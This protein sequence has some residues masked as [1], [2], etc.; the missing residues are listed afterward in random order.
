M[1]KFNE[2][3]K[4]YAMTM[5][6][7][8]IVVII[9]A[10]VAAIFI[11]MPKKNVSKLDRAKYYIAYD[12]L[13]KLQNEQLA[14]AGEVKIGLDSFASAVNEYLNTMGNMAA[15]ANQQ[16]TL[17]NGMILTVVNA[18]VIDNRDGEAQKDT[19]GDGVI[20]E[21]DQRTQYPYLEVTVDIDGDTNGLPAV[22]LS[23]LH[24]FWLYKDG[25]VEPCFFIDAGGNFVNGICNKNPNTDPNC[26]AV[27]CGGGNDWINFKVYTIDG[28]GNIQFLNDRIS[29]DVTETYTNVPYQKA[30]NRYLECMYE[31]YTPVDAADHKGSLDCY[32][33][34]NPPLK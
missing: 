18:G 31:G 13:N 2:K 4:K 28:N 19:N 17:T 29:G 12:L 30:R 20:D 34:A 23:D 16:V 1:E 5:A 25:L 26:D 11:A 8:V 7:I 21:H 6:E 14:N 33:E 24:K 27:H 9:V 10:I 32:M 3:Y 22:A 15:G